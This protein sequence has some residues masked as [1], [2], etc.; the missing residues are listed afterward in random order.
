M[1]VFLVFA[2]HE[3]IIVIHSSLFSTYQF[4]ISPEENVPTFI[5]HVV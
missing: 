4:S 2:Y 1:F 5:T 3:L